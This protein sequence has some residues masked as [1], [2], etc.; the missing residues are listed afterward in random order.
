MVRKKALVYAGAGLMCGPKK[1]WGGWVL[2][3]RATVAGDAHGV[4]PQA[5]K[6]PSERFLIGSI[7]G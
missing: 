1:G 4:V 5:F 6:G 3:L 2:Y 7:V